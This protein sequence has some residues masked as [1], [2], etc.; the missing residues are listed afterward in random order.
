MSKPPCRRPTRR[1]RQTDKEGYGERGQR[2]GR[3]PD[4]GVRQ[5]T[6]ASTPPLHALAV[7]EILLFRLRAGSAVSMA[8]HTTGVIVHFISLGPLFRS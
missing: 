4:Q 8:T 1:L 3:Q 6:R 7:T 5:R 2:L